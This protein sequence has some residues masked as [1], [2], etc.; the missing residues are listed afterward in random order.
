MI[1]IMIL[2]LIFVFYVLF[3]GR[4]FL[5]M[6]KGVKVWVLSSSKGIFG[7]I[8]ES[9][10]TPLLILWTTEIVLTAIGKPL[11]K[12]SYFWNNIYIRYAGLTLCTLGLIIFFLALLSFGN[13][14][15]IG[16]DEVN[17]NELITGGIFSFTRNPIFLFMDMFFLG[18]FLV[19]PNIFF[20]LCFI[21]IIL[22]IHIQILREEKFLSIKFGQKYEEYKRQVRRYL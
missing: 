19:Y 6:K 3:I 22:S 13:A 20:L 2:I 14:W 17:S 9:L 4:S 18:T 1:D 11:S 7:K 8:I 5:L 12:V 15:R 21:L 10:L 16:I